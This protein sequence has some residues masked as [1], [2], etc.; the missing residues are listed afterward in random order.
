MNRA[1][2]IPRTRSRNG[3]A[4]HNA[5]VVQRAAFDVVSF[6]FLRVPEVRAS[7]HPHIAI[8]NSSSGN[9]GCIIGKTP[10]AENDQTNEK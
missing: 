9:L 4:K 2:G 8:K 6:G 1:H 3:G 7:G 5:I 10:D